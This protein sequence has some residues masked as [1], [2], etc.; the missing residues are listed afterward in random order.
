MSTPLPTI[1]VEAVDMVKKFQCLGCTSGGA[2]TLEECG[3][4][5]P[6]PGT[7]HPASCWNCDNHSAGTFM[8][9]VGKIYLGMPKGF[10][11][12]GL[13]AL[14]YSQEQHKAIR[15]WTKAPDDL[16]NRLNVP[17]WAT[18]YEGYLLVRTY[19]PR[20]NMTYLDVVKDGALDMVPDAINVAE[21]VDE[22]D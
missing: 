9:G 7:G 14:T 15:L 21:F 19:S 20:I 2:N 13:N 16:W 17:V 10:N 22:I 3:D 8:S 6:S 18:E 12:V 11:R 1:P 5:N 4:I